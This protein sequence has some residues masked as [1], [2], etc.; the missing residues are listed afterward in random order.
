MNPK[1]YINDS[2]AN[3]KTLSKREL[4][5]LVRFQLFLCFICLMHN[6]IYRKISLKHLRIKTLMILKRF[7]QELV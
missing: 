1:E 6:F 7:W 5:L 4:S 2:F 3:V